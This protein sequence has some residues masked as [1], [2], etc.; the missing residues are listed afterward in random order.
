MWNYFLMGPLCLLCQC[1]ELFVIRGPI[2]YIGGNNDLML[3]IR[4]NLGI[5]L[6]I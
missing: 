5:T 4:R 6:N 2:R 3:G 1:Q